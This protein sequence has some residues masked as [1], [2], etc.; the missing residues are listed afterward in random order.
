MQLND[1]TLT[2]SATTLSS[3][4]R[5]PGV[6][7]GGAILENGNGVHQKPSPAL[8]SSAVES[9]KVEACHRDGIKTE[10]FHS[11][12]NK[13][14]HLHVNDLKKPERCSDSVG[15]DVTNTKRNRDDSGSESSTPQSESRRISVRQT[16]LVYRFKEIVV[17]KMHGYMHVSLVSHTR[18]KN[19]VNP[20][21][22]GI[23]APLPAST[24]VL[25]TF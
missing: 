19:A 1:V 13:I 12:S 10:R 2:T 24:A 4:K 22:C 23:D 17:R 5:S 8:P 7:G 25:L 11:Y 9:K 16:E 18:A 14:K 3:V 6:C 21:V 20:K 15:S